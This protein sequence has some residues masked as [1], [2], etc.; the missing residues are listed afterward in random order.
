MAVKLS[1]LIVGERYSVVAK[2]V[3]SIVRLV[4]RRFQL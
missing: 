1:E 2:W 3:M 4:S